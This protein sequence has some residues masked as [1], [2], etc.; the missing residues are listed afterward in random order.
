MAGTVSPEVVQKAV[1]EPGGMA[2]ESLEQRT[3]DA[4][5]KKGQ[6]EALNIAAGR[7]I[8]KDSQER[9]ANENIGLR[10]ADGT[11]DRPDPSDAKDRYDTSVARQVL[12]EKFDRVGYEGLNTGEQT[13]IK[14]QVK[15]AILNHPA[16]RDYFIARG[17]A[18]D[19]EAA[20]MAERYLKNPQYRARV[21]ALVVERGEIILEDKASAAEI[22][23]VRLEKE[24]T[25]LA[26]EK[27]KA[28]K[29]KTDAENDLKEHNPVVDDASAPGGKRAGK[30]F[31]QINSL[32]TEAATKNAEV[33]K[34]QADRQD[35][36]EDLNDLKQDLNLRKAIDQGRVKATS[37]VVTPP[38]ETT[39][40]GEMKK[41]QGGITKADADILSAQKEAELKTR[42]ADSYET[43]RQR[44]TQELKDAKTKL[45]QIEEQIKTNDKDLTTK[46][47][48]ANTL[49]AEKERLE[50][51]Y[52]KG[53][54]DIFADAGR[55][56]VD[57][58]MKESAKQA[59]ELM[60]AEATKETDAR[61]KR[62]DEHLARR[63]LDAKNNFDKTRIT[64]D[65]AELMKPA[66]DIAIDGETFYLNGAEQALV[67]ALRGSGFTE[68]Q[69][70]EMMKD[71]AFVSTNSATVAQEILT[72]S[73][74][75]GGL[76]Q[77]DVIAIAKSTW[78]K[79]M[80]DK[81]LTGRDDLR[82]AVDTAL[83]KG[84]IKWSESVFEQI[85][86]NWKWLFLILAILA[87]VGIFAGT[88]G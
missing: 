10:K 23:R 9:A 87:A 71:T 33:K 7:V 76:S 62:L 60:Q 36:T 5:Q 2:P 24:K 29:A 14:K 30:I 65:R 31:E 86:H 82:K 84:A 1:V 42:Q 20:T 67:V 61:K 64:S 83:G 25:D 46:T 81:A 3:A 47:A 26:A 74:L 56:R 16:L 55:E 77:K 58:L 19:G 59:S 15:V 66:A 28:E 41:V 4:L 48:Q 11:K 13:V 37:L 40:K 69:I 8:D 12:H 50:K 53:I 6:E 21:K 85:K 79:G 27:T 75:T 73:F 43:D 72:Y 39:L 80:V 54:Q 70:R 44:L 51:E 35:L 88:R 22:E 45:D 57:A 63:W 38:D 52:V 78:G 18:A 32:R 34:L 49:K 17:A 68:P